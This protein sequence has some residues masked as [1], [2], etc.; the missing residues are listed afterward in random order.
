MGPTIRIASMVGAPDLESP[1]L[2]PY[3]GDLSAAFG[4][5]ATL[6]YDGAGS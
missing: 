4:R 1:T 6:G 3:S 5:L 2:A